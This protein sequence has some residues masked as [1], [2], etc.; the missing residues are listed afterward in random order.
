M[1]A[2]ARRL[3]LLIAL[4]F[5]ADCALALIPVIDFAAGH[6]WPRLSNLFNL[7]TEQTIPTWY[8]SMQWFC[9]GAMFASFASHAWHRHMRGALCITALALACL[10]FSVDEIAEIHERLG[11][12]ADALMSGGT[13]KDTALWSTGLWP[14]LI[15]I[16]VIAA[17]AVVVRGTRH[18][19]L[20]RA[21]RAL[22]LLIAGFIVMF[23]GAVG[24]E[25]V[26]NFVSADKQSAAFLAQV[27]VEETMEM[28]GVTLIAWSAFSLLEAYGLDISVHPAAA[29]SAPVQSVG[30]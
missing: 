6:P 2:G 27:V 1:F 4:L 24:V 17:I 18:I 22:V 9:A 29:A 25:L 14:F 26:A 7:D 13:R 5:A 19:F 21:P 3:P 30:S 10:V 8:S 23:T 15:G 28:L 16:P 11:F 20:A 12:A